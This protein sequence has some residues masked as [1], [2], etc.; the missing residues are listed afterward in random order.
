MDTT[1]T[2]PHRSRTGRVL[3]GL[4]GAVSLALG[5]VGIFLPGLPTTVF[6]LIA[7][8]CFAKASPRL[9]QWL[10][11]H[12]LFGPM[13]RD[14]EQHRSLTRRTK[15][16]AVGSMSVMVGTSALWFFAGR[17]LV[18]GLLLALGAIGAFVVLR[19]PTR[20]R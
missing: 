2:Q 1:P 20:P 13:V 11:D 19:I 4:A 5:M 9:H 17:P 16:V 8:A 15:V 6:V 14:W 3:F 18:Q 10:L 12:R 7:A